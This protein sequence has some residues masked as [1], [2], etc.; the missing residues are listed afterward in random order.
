MYIYTLT[1][2][3][4]FSGINLLTGVLVHPCIGQL[5]SSTLAND[6]ASQ[7]WLKINIL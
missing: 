5:A 3:V 7:V 6:E 4:Y 2:R 1:H